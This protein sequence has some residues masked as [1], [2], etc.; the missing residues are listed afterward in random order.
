MNCVRQTFISVC[1]NAEIHQHVRFYAT[2]KRVQYIGREH[3]AHNL[4]SA[5]AGED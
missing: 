2:L 5:S 4:I 1:V 3:T